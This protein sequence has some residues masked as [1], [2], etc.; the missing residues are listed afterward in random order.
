MSELV[1]RWT[2]LKHGWSLAII[3]VVVAGLI[4]LGLWLVAPRL[5][6]QFNQLAQ[7]LPRSIEHLQ[8]SLKRHTLTRFLVG[9]TPTSQPIASTTN[10][11][12]SAFGVLSSTVDALAAIVVILVAG[13][14]L[15][16]EPEVYVDGLMKLVPLRGRRRARE[17]LEAAGHTLRWWIIGQAISMLVIGIL[18]TVGLWLV[19]MPLFIALGVL[20]GL[21]NF[22]PTLGPL[23]SFVPVVLLALAIS[24]AK[25]L[26]VFVVY[27]V[28]HFLEG[29]II[30]PLIQRETVWLP[31]ALTIVIQVLLGWLVGVLGIM[32]AAPLTAVGIVIIQRLYVEDFLG[33]WGE[34]KKRGQG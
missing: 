24:P 7:Q 32:F 6:E 4:S 21:L 11:L 14:Y 27:L 22:I 3:V 34:G 30:T 26:W 18:A 9:G 8:E 20:T 1:S 17:V 33:D 23:I 16:V 12:S 2:G 13:F 10:V 19:R 31:P 5:G 15:A 25:A 28:I 29:Y